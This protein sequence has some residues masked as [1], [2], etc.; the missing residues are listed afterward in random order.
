MSFRPAVSLSGVGILGELRAPRERTSLLDPGLLRIPGLLA[1]SAST[2]FSRGKEYYAPRSLHRLQAD[3]TLYTGLLNDLRCAPGTCVAPSRY[4]LA[5]HVLAKAIRVVDFRAG[6]PGTGNEQLAPFFETITQCARLI[7]DG[8]L[9]RPTPSSRSGLPRSMPP[10]PA[11]NQE[12]V[13]RAFVEGDNHLLTLTA[14]RTAPR[15][16]GPVVG[17]LLGGGAAAAVTAAAWNTGMSL[18]KVS[19]Y[20]DTA[21]G[22]SQVWGTPLDA[23]HEATVIDD[24]C[25]TGDTL[26]AAAALVEGL[27]G[28]APARRAVEWHW[29]K[30]LR[31]R[32]YEHP[33]RVFA[34]EESDVLAPWAFRHHRLVNTLAE[35]L[36]N[37]GSHPRLTTAD[38]LAHS[39]TVLAMLADALPEQM[40]TD[41][42][43]ELL[44]EIRQADRHS[45]RGVPDAWTDLVNRCHDCAGPRPHLVPGQAE[46]SDA[47]AAGHL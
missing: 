22:G 15:P 35:H 39:H 12:A 42:P 29:E 40:W 17:V 38:W 33:G 3:I 8:L 34:P 36:T 25:G 32:V 1:F 44:R 10:L 19:R 13:P 18:I 46:P 16:G 30:L 47:D 21:R 43:L 37:G 45:R 7:A 24:N 41:A 14:A 6:V 23:G 2:V 5:D 20:D 27:T 26:K 9:G 28:R 4:V 31:G 11:A